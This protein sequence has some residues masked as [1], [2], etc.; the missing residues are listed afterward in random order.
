MGGGYPL[1]LFREQQNGHMLKLKHIRHPLRTLGVAKEVF[2]TQLNMKV[3]GARGDARYKED[4]R[5]NMRCVQEG[6]AP[7]LNRSADTAIL[8][9]ICDAYIQAAEREPLAK[10]AYRPT[11]WWSELRRTSLGPVGRALA[12]R[13][14][15]TL[16]AMYGNFFRDP[17]SAGLIG[18]PSGLSETYHGGRFDERSARF[19]LGNALHRIDY[20]KELTGNRFALHDLVGPDVGNPFGVF[21]EGVLVRSGTESQHYFAQRIAGLLPRGD[22]V[23]SEIGGGF[24]GVAYYLLRDRVQTSYWS[25]DVPE[26]VALASYYLLKSFPQRK[27]LL[28]RDQPL[29]GGSFAEC[30]VACLPAFELENLPAKSADVAFSSHTL[31]GLT[32]AAMHEYL[33]QIVR[34]TRQFF[35][36]VGRDRESNAF[37]KLIQR[38]YPA[39][40]LVDK[41]LLDWNKQKT[42]DDDE[43]E[44]IYEVHSS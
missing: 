11:K 35:L 2:A 30:S 25:F 14:L 36:Y 39:L 28:Y 32:Q 16:G 10:P 3:L 17:C 34:T 22:A 21:L 44:C 29:T 6:F 8:T 23:V 4:A 12:S 18:V 24:G 19:F 42:L 41:Q 20:W 31:S 7:R 38:C 37:R 1:A 33:G 26:S 40:R 5:Y 9:A 43:V 13:D 15:P 27:F